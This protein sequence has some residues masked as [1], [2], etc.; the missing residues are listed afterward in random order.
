ME[1]L[2]KIVRL[3]LL[4]GVLVFTTL[5]MTGVFLYY[6]YSQDLPKLDRLSDYN[7]P[8]VSEVYSATGLKIGEF[9][10]EKRYILRPDEL[11]KTLVQAFVASEDDRFFE[12]QGI[13]Y[14][15]IIRAFIENLKAGHIVQGGSTITQQ[16]T[17]SLLLSRERTLSRKIKEAILATRIERKLNK[18][19]ILHLYL[20]QIFF[21][22]RAYGIEAAAKNYFHKSAR[23]LNIAE[24]ALIA[25]LAKA[26]ATYSPITNWETAKMRQEYVI[27]RMHSVGYITK[28][29]A[30]KA[31][32]YP[33]KIYRAKTDKE[34]NYDYAPW[35][36][37]Y[38]RRYIQKK[39]GDD[40]PYTMGLRIETTAD[41]D[42][43]KAA[44]RAVSRGLRELDK[45]QGYGGPIQTIPE[46]AIAEFSQ[47]NH[48]KITK[49]RI[50]GAELVEVSLPDEELSKLPTTIDPEKN[51]EAVITAVNSKEQT[52]DVLVG[53]VPGKILVHDYTWA[54][55]RNLNS[56]GY[57]N[58]YYIRDPRGTFNV[59]DVVLVR[60]KIPLAGEIKTKGYTPSVAYFSL[61]QEP[62]AES[63]LF[64]YE[65][66]DGFVRAIVGGNDFKKSEFDRATQALRQTGSAIKPLI[67]S[68]ALD[69]G[70]TLN[71]I[72]ED[73]PVYYE[74][75]PG[76][77]WS[78][79]NYGG[80]FKGPTSFRSGLVN[81][82]NVVTVR[83]LMD[84]GTDYATAY[85]RKLGITTT[86]QRYY[87]MALGANSMKLSEL[88]RAYG[89]FVNNGILPELV[90]IKRITD[91]N[92]NVLEEYKPKSITPFTEQIEARKSEDE[93]TSTH[94]EY[95]EAL[96][97]G[98][99]QPIAEEKLKLTEIEKK[100]LHGGYI[101][102]GYAISP[103]TAAAMVQ[104]MNDIVN[105]GTG[106]KVRELKR[107]AAGKTGTTNDETDVWF[108]GFVP[109]LFA[110]VWVGFDE[111]QKIGGRETGGK[112]AAPIFLYYMQ[113]VLKN[114]PVAQF[115]LP[116]DALLSGLETTPL[117]Q[118][119]PNDDAEAGGIRSSGSGTEFL[120]H[121][122]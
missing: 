64:S 42:M 62:E 50:E 114:R 102:D 45:R 36:T 53:N 109:D 119:S 10:S 72:I 120:I 92:G 14:P 59:G 12:H 32:A 21:G 13:D 80:G 6:Y 117:E 118:S 89:T 70:Y 52:L 11:P 112:T 54:R 35:F 66:A 34:F 43:Q 116:K 74:Y 65:P 87:S 28:D 31:R 23:E 60:R 77:F 48:L 56:T 79:Q 88:S 9:W 22:N 104:L 93:K 91:K 107:P 96:K 1:H 29:Q 63:A 17:K 97:A 40:A 105:Y 110:G 30:K 49:E 24:S 7:P 98:A 27:D 115:D 75:L 16:V 41:L 81:S 26:P 15:G 121:D 8:V 113:E 76:K 18:D 61:E 73:A 83:I 90:F 19:E 82:R 4:T 57:D 100:I 86:I 2:Y 5:V 111:V 101:P 67:Y 25:G 71:T 95:N 58:T 68:A 108:V 99:E 122:F 46:S 103:R 3:I 55:K 20:N 37:E 84:I 47:K 78:P 94:A 85:A 44:D 69:K 33:L 51:Y 39:Y 106:Y 38:V